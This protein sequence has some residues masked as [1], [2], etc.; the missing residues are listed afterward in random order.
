MPHVEIS[1]FPAALSEDSAR[2]LTEAI[3]GAVTEAFAVDQG[4]VSVGLGSVDPAH[5]QERVYRP[6]ISH[7]ADRAT[8][9]RSPNY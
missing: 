2:R 6:L 3:V 4:V 9:L 7:R 8:L 5:W 1:H